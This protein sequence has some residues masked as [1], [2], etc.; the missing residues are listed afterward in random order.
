MVKELTENPII[1]NQKAVKVEI[2]NV[3]EKKG[4]NQVDESISQ[5][6]NPIKLQ[7]YN[8]AVDSTIVMDD[9]LRVALPGK[10]VHIRKAGQ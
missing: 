10:T 9:Q 2:R 8:K 3:V 5:I 6:I 4:G 1:I 7:V